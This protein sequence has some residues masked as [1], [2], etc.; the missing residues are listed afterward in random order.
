MQIN[1]SGEYRIKT[2]VS[3]E[4]GAIFEER[5][6]GGSE[7]TVK[8]WDSRSHSSELLE[9]FINID[10]SDI[11]DVIEFVGRYGKLTEPIER[12]EINKDKAEITIDIDAIKE[13]REFIRKISNVLNRANEKIYTRKEKEINEEREKNIEDNSMTIFL[14]I[15]NLL[16]ESTILE[17]VQMPEL[18][19]YG[20]DIP[21]LKFLM[22]FQRAIRQG[23][24]RNGNDCEKE[25]YEAKKK[26]PMNKDAIIKKFQQEKESRNMKTVN[27]KF[28]QIFVEIFS[29]KAKQFM[30]NFNKEKESCI[31]EK[32]LIW[33]QFYNILDWNNTKLYKIEKDENE[34]FVFKLSEEAKLNFCYPP[35]KKIDEFKNEDKGNIQINSLE[36]VLKKISRYI[37]EDYCTFFCDSVQWRMKIL[38]NGKMELVPENINTIRALMLSIV[39]TYDS[40]TYLRTCENCKRFFFPSA[41]HPQS[42]CCSSKCSD[43]LA[44]RIKRKR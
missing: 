1:M 25:I 12:R 6:P 19:E 17:C 36:V 23:F 40:K 29:S 34:C 21:V 26:N 14:E 3:M 24:I 22:D 13:L 39:F 10:Y 15:M 27:E 5:F 37:M 28:R 9:S 7:C 31:E 41:T 32:D 35:I 38:K 4:D 33:Y 42:R 8:Y 16:V 43:R 2:K 30:D 20:I 18:I 44:K 11:N